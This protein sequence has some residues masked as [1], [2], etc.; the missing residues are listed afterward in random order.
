MREHRLYQVD[1]LMRRYGFKA[2]E[3]EFGQGG[4]LSLQSDPKQLWA[5]KH[6]ERFPINANSAPYYELLRVPGLGPVTAR[7]ILKRRKQAALTR[8]EDISK[9]T[10][11]LQKAKKYLRF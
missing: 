6:P 8:I 2:G 1:F 7:R 10:A 3:I 4:N 5:Q 11:R 9:L